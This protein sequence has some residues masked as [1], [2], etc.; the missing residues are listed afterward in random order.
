MLLMFAAVH[1][2]YD[3]VH[4]V[5]EGREGAGQSEYQHQL[6]Q[7]IRALSGLKNTYVRT[8][9]RESTYVHGAIKMVPFYVLLTYKDS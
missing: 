9:K 2:N 4:I 8:G 6:D 3:V 1:D 7:A 5:G